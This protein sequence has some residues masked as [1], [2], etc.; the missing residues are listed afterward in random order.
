[1]LYNFIPYSKFPKLVANIP[2]FHFVHTAKKHYRTTPFPY[3]HM[4]LSLFSSTNHGPR[5]YLD[6]DSSTTN[7]TSH[8]VETENSYDANDG[9]GKMG[10]NFSNAHCQVYSDGFSDEVEESDEERGQG[11]SSFTDRNQGTKMDEDWRR[12]E[13]HEDEFRHPLVREICRLIECRS[14]WNHKHEGK[15][16]HLLRGLKPRLVCAVLL[17]QSDERVALDF[18]YW[19]DRQW[20]Y[21]HYPIVYCVMLDV[22]SKT[23]LCQGARRVLRL[24]ARR[25]IQ[26]G[27]QDFCCVMVSYSRAGKLRNA[28]QV[29]TMMQKAD[30][31]ELISEMP[32]KGCSPDKVSYYTVMGFLCKNRRIREVRDVIEKMEDTKLLADQV[33]YNTLIHMLSKHQHADEALQFLRE[34][35]KRG[36][37]VDK[38]GYSAIV[39][40]Y[41]KEGRMDQAKE[42]VNEMFTRGCIPDVVT[43]TAIINGFSQAGEVGQ[44]R[45][46]LQQMYK[47]GC[48]PNTVSYTAFLKGL[49]QKGNSSEA[50]EMMKASEEQWWTPNAITYSVVMHGFRREGKLSDACDVVREM[51]G[52]GFFPTPVE[53]NLLIQSLC[54]IGRVDEAKKFMEECLNMGCAVNAVNFTTILSAG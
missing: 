19:S 35:Q 45:K 21:R 25:G 50:R 41:C 38:V 32:L 44:A 53:I 15:M 18:F 9:F 51:I 30:A 17:S 40:S 49:C 12:I 42:I 3:I 29:L 46:M 11:N 27:P 26:R 36:F 1:M 10:F 31:M 34:A 39:D 23:K 47:H 37:Q 48:K 5:S 22:L 6:S 13:I 52:K 28:M 8:L 7:S 54:R 4:F 20:R 16:R 2:F 43:Y 14:A 33:T 24:M